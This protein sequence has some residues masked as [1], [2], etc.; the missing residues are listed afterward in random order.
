MKKVK[1]FALALIATV[2]VSLFAGM[3]ATNKAQASSNLKIEFNARQTVAEYGGFANAPDYTVLYPDEVSTVKTI[4]VSP[5]GKPVQIE[6]GVFGVSEEGKYSVYVEVVGVDETKTIYNYDVVSESKNYPVPAEK[7][8]LPKAFLA[9]ESY[10]LKIAK[11]NDLPNGKENC[12]YKVFVTDANGRREINGEYVPTVS[13]SGESV[14]VEY[15]AS[16]TESKTLTYSVPVQIANKLDESLGIP[17]YSFKDLFITENVS[18]SANGEA[19]VEFFTENGNSSI[20][21]C[22]PLN[23]NFG[24]VVKSAAGENNFESVTFS[25]ADSKNATERITI[26]IKNSASANSVVLFNGDKTALY[27]GNF[28]EGISITFDNDSLYFKD[29]ANQS[30]YKFSKTVNGVD[31]NGFSS[32]KVYCEITVNGV[33]AASKLTVQE[34]CLQS[35]SVAGDAG[36]DYDY[37][38]PKLILLDLISQQLPV[39]STAITPRAVLADVLDVAPK[40]KLSVKY[41][42]DSRTKED[43]VGTDGKIMND[44]SI[45]ESHQ[46]VLDKIGEYQLAYEYVDKSGNSDVSYYSIYSM[47]DVK[48][49]VTLKDNV[50]QVVKCGGSIKIPSVDYSDNVTPNEKLYARIVVSSPDGHFKNVDGGSEFKLTEKGE[51]DILYYVYDEAYNMSFISIRIYCV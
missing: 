34:L 11:F 15:V 24:A 47:D 2:S 18:D 8:N 29:G 14:D 35:M 43:V 50:K 9:G 51:Y 25:L 10:D 26:E 33:V 37:R 28:I 19:G 13:I 1:I 3:V 5:S 45:N 49:T 39:K 23:A 21:Y 6:N 48:P 30:L 44:L 31:F 42:V 41:L 40:G 20:S 38:E 27:S 36:Y 22:L 46:F 32:K 17:V 4:V 12:E 16:G 7:I